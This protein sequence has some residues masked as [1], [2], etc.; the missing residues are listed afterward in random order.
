MNSPTIEEVKIHRDILA[1]EIL[2]KCQ[3]YEQRFEVAI[4][5]IIL[6]H[7]RPFGEMHSRVDSVII[8]MRV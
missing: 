5:A 1:R 3:A 6:E 4:T 7:S 2:E 8:E